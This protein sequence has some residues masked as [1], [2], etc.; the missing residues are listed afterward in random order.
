MISPASTATCAQASRGTVIEPAPEAAFVRT[1]QFGTGAKTRPKTGTLTSGCY[2]RGAETI[3][4]IRFL[5]HGV[6]GSISLP[7]ESMGHGKKPACM[8]LLS[9][10]RTRTSSRRRCLRGASSMWV[11]G[12]ACYLA[13]CLLLANWIG[14]SP[15][16]H[17]WLEHGGVGIEHSHR[18]DS[19]GLPHSLKAHSHLHADG[20]THTHSAAWERHHV[21]SKASLLASGGSSFPTPVEV[22][23]GVLR[24]MRGMALWISKNEQGQS[25]VPQASQDSESR[26]NPPDHQ[27]HGLA[28][29][30]AEGLVDQ[31]ETPSPELIRFSWV[32]IPIWVQRERHADQRPSGPISNRGPPGTHRSGAFAESLSE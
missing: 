28:E 30:L 26:P 4:C 25:T 17:R 27:H 31:A 32:V 29:L 24:T 11:R 20:V 21:H 7:A 14:L 19:S 5:V 23:D 3:S 2:Q 1:P 8:Q 6:N 9:Q 18:L 15:W 16:L 10:D 12:A 22:L 13:I